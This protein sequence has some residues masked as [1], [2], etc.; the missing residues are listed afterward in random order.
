MASFSQTIGRRLRQAARLTGAGTSSPRQQMI[1]LANGRK[2][3]ATHVPRSE[4]ADLQPGHELLHVRAKHAH[5]PYPACIE[6]AT[7]EGNHA[8]TLAWGWRGAGVPRGQPMTTPQQVLYYCELE[9]ILR[10]ELHETSYPD[11]VATI[12]PNPNISNPN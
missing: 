6:M 9:A 10:H 12:I 2:F 5:V 3:W 8:R 4:W 7:V 1:A 11:V